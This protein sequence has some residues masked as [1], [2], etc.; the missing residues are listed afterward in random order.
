MK[1]I[2]WLAGWYPNIIHPYTGDFIERH[3]RAASLNNRITVLFLMKD[4]LTATGKKYS[5]EKRTYNDH[6]TALILYYSPYSKIQ[7]IET[8]FS[9]LRYCIFLAELIRQYIH[10]NGKPDL[11]HVHVGWKAGLLGLYCK[12]KYKLEYA[13]SEHW[14]GFVSES[15]PSFRSSSFFMKMLIRKIYRNA[16]RCSAVSGQLAIALA[17]SLKIKQPDVIPNVVD[18]ELFKVSGNK[19]GI[20]RFIHISEFNEQK[21]PEQLFAAVA[22]LKRNTQK[23][24]ELL[25]FAPDKT[26]VSALA[27]KYDIANVIHY[28]SYVPQEILALEMNHS[29]VLIL[30]SRHETF[31]CVVIEALASG[32]PVIVSDI[33]VMHEIVKEHTG[34]I[35]PLNDPTLL[36]EKM[37]WMMNNKDS[38]NSR[39]LSD[40]AAA[41]YSFEEV[42]KLFDI[43]YKKCIP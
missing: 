9:G 14:S 43:F 3:A 24:F 38:F 23:H 13:V 18:T 33:P 32:I 42:G 17:G 26:S 41:H 35:V 27:N 12:W 1:N 2:L 8:M 25:V 39:I 21:N 37:M 15:P 19:T 20:F 16:K 30:Y 6:C 22:Q 7:F 34:V 11:L 28:R 40:Q 36:A 31:G 29:D 5:L 4:D 10:E